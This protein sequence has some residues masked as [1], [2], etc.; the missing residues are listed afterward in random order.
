MEPSA[1]NAAC[2]VIKSPM[3]VPMAHAHHRM[4]F[5]A[6]VV[7]EPGSAEVLVPLDLVL[8]SGAVNGAGTENAAT[9]T[10]VVGVTPP[11][12]PSNVQ[13]APSDEADLNQQTRSRSLKV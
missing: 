2:G 1:V 12:T 9:Y 8:P 6:N 4:S 11:D 5:A 7:Y 3:L 10:F 13:L